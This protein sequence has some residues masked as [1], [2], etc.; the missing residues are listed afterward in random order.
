[1]PPV[2][3]SPGVVTNVDTTPVTAPQNETTIDISPL[4]SN[5]RV[6]GTNDFRTSPSGDVNCGFTRSTDGGVTWSSGILTGITRNNPGSP[7]DYDAAG[8]PS[9][10]I[11]DNGTVFYA[12]LAFDRSYGR[13]AMVVAKSKDGGATW[14]T[15]VAIAQ[16]NSS[17][18]FHDK[19]MI[20]V[21]NSPTSRFHRRIYVAWTEFMGEP[22]SSPSQEVVS[23]SSDGGKTWSTPVV[24]SG[25][26][27]GVEG[28]HPAVGPDGTV[29]VS[30]CKGPLICV[31]GSAP[32][33]IEV[34]KSTDGGKT[35]SAPVSAASLTS[36]PTTLPGNNFRI[37][38]LPTTAVDPMNGNVYVSYA[39]WTSRADVYVVRSNDGGVTWS[40][41]VAMRP[42]REDQ[43]FQWMRVSPT[44]NIWVCYYDQHWNVG[45]LLDMSCSR[46]TDGGITFGKAKRFTTASSDPSHD[47]F[48]GAFIGDYTGLALDAG[49]RPHPLWTDTRSGNADAWTAN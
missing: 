35:W 47:G 9:V 33:Q 16:S 8:D 44:G 28:S 32:S 23:H 26:P 22:D 5:V 49:G 43:F 17:S 45:T 11:A 18:L 41:P 3:P 39:G 4:D 7:F 13:S 40:H 21:D 25:A 20:T 1:M 10:F 15:P 29:Y 38:S 42:N 34:V 24:V 19:E 12:C 46:S 48:G 14:S 27:S 37:N 2:R 30:W 31:N 36:L 6:G